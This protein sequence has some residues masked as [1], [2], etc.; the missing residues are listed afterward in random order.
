MRDRK[1]IK[2]LAHTLKKDRYEMD[3]AHLEKTVCLARCIYRGENPKQRIGFGGLLMRQVR[4]MGW[5]VWLIQIFSLFIM[6]AGIHT[7]FGNRTLNSSHISYI[8]CG[9]AILMV[10]ALTPVI[11][12]SFKYKMHEVETASY[13][14]GSRILIAQMIMIVGGVMVMLFAI[15]LFTSVRYEYGIS[16]ITFS[17]F[18]P[19][20]AS[21][22]LYLY[23]LRHVRP[24]VL[25]RVC[26]AVGGILIAVILFLDRSRT[27]NL[28]KLPKTI[29]W[30]MC[31]VGIIFCAIQVR[32]MWEQKAVEI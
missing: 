27:F 32:C 7:V 12:R 1:L 30:G 26:N 20:F 6:L 22:N 18:L 29:G 5:R 15:I 13:F 28:I 3:E 23:L 4:F 31:I 11:A 14:S 25:I 17:L 2:E 9:T 19:F 16:E 21:G 10:W 24:H 8:L